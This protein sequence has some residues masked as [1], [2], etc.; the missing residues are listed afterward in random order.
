MT[1]QVPALHTSQ[2]TQENEFERQKSL[3]GELFI[4]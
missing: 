3:G 4:Q 2:C 1:F